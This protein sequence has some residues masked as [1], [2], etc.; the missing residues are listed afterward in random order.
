MIDFQKKKNYDGSSLK[1]KSTTSDGVSTSTCSCL[2]ATTAGKRHCCRRTFVGVHKG[3]HLLINQFRQR[4]FPHLHTDSVFCRSK[5]KATERLISNDTEG[6]YRE[7]VVARDWFEMLVSGYLYHKSGRECWLD[8]WG[9][10]VTENDSINNGA[11][12]LGYDWQG[13]VIDAH[14]LY[15]WPSSLTDTNH[16][17]CR[18]LADSS[19]EAGLLV[20]TSFALTRW[21]LPFRDFIQSRRLDGSGKKTVYVHMNELDPFSKGYGALTNRLQHFFAPGKH[22]VAAKL[23]PMAN[24]PATSVTVASLQNHSGHDTSHNPYLRARLK[25]II[26]TIDTEMWNDVVAKNHEWPPKWSFQ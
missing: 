15:P 9:N 7:V 3:G 24:T 21:L 10:P 13:T 16:S 8:L 11:S 22:A 6:D 23:L 25:T 4:E 1:K 20:Y 18:Y 12:L 19:E 17:L 26:R 2:T 5:S 14:P